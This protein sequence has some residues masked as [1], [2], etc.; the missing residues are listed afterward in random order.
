MM[1][2]YY[3]DVYGRA[4]AIRMLLWH[5]KVEFEDVRLPL[6][7]EEFPKWREEHPEVKLEFGQIPVIEE[8]GEWKAQSM[9]ILR[10]LSRRHG[11]Y[12]ETDPFVAWQ[13]D[14]AMDSLWD[15]IP[16]L[17]IVRDEPDMFKK[18][19]MGMQLLTGK[20]PQW[21]AIHEKR[22]KEKGSTNFLV[23]DS[24]TIADFAWA[25]LIFSS[26]FNDGNEH[27]PRLRA[28]FENFPLLMEYQTNLAK[29]LE[30]YLAARP[31]PREL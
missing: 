24:M 26:F 18:V 3:Y 29:T 9:A 20:L 1:K 14:S 17:L 13:I 19:Y 6:T 30:G 22:L 27:A 5:A 16:D 28:V 15:I 10:L 7:P 12:P 25:S 4:E 11:Y 23:G 21:L 31:Q 8:N 2:L